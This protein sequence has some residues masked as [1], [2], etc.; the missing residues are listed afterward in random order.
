MP[1]EAGELAY[2]QK[3][4]EYL[5]WAWAV[6]DIDIEPFLG[7]ASKVNVTLPNLVTKR[8]DDIVKVRPEYK[9]RSHFLL[10]AAQHEFKK[11]NG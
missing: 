4:P 6:V 11:L 7:K 2:W 5:G 9:S 8:I 10:L 3:D 1:P